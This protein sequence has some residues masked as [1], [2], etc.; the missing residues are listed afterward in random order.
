MNQTVLVAGATGVLGSRIVHHLLAEPHTTIR[1]L[2]RSGALANVTKKA[3]LTPHLDRGAELITGDLTDHGSLQHA[4]MGVDVIVSAVQGGSDVIVDGQIALLQAG[5]QTGVRRFIP[6]DFALD[7]FKSPPGEHKLFDMRRKADSVIVQSGLEF[8]NVLNGVFMDLFVAPNPIFN[9]KTRIARTWGMGNER[10]EAT[11]IEDVARYTAKA[12]LD[13][14]LPNGKFA[15][16]GQVISFDDVSEA[17]A[18]VLGHAFERERLGSLADLK[19]HIEDLRADETHQRLAIMNTYQL[20][21]L[22]GQTALQNLQNN[23]YPEIRPESIQEFLY[24]KL[25]PVSDRSGAIK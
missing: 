16:A 15:I 11:S 10:F 6:S 9:L 21:M 7:L 1:M 23:R 20:Y 18:R 19:R 22:T 25:A 2:V 3:L 17:L 5:K 14:D 4:T 24:R 12:A 8:V 13:R